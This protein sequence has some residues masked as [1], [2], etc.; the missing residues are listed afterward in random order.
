MSENILYRAVQKIKTNVTKLR[1]LI[2][3][4]FLPSVI[5]VLQLLPDPGKG[6]FLPLLLQ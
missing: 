5:L 3:K 2:V 1:V 6:G 4:F